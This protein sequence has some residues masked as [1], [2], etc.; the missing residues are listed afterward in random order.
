MTKVLVVEDD[1]SFAMLLQRCLEP[2]GISMEVAPDVEEGLTRA[3]NGDFEVVLTDLYL[4][5]ATA[6]DL[7]PRLR[8]AR[9]HLP[10]IIMTAKH[11][12]ETAIMATQY[13]AYDYFAKPDA[14]DF[15][16]RVRHSWP[17]VIDLADMI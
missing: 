15:D 16:V 5:G 12:T 3:L 7:I 13:G 1:P 14:F 17:W 9:P 10:A 8:K 11:T 4:G 2:E 6:L